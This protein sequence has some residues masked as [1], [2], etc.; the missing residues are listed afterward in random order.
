[1]TRKEFDDLVRRMERRLAGRPAALERSATRWMALGLAGFLA[2]VGL[3]FALGLV[4]FIA[5]IVLPF[6][7]GVWLL[8][9]GVLILLFATSQAF[10]FFSV[11]HAPP[12]GHALRAAEAPA[13]HEALDSLRRDLQCR[14]FDDVRITM[15]FNAGIREIP[16][17]GFLGWPRSILEIGLPL[18]EAL[19]PDELRAVLAHEMAHGSGRHARSAGRIYRLHR[20]WAVLFERMQRPASGS[21]D[22]A[23]RAA[24]S[25]FAGWYWPRLHARAMVLS[26]AHEY[27]ADRVAAEC[28]GT[29][30]VVSALW[31]ME[32]W[33]P[34]LGERFWEDLFR[35]AEESPDPPEDI[36]DRMRSAYESRPAPDDASRW[37]ER[38]LSRTTG[39]D[40]TH[41]AFGDRVRALGVS[42]EDVRRI[43]YPLA[44]RPSAAQALLGPDRGAIEAGLADQWRRSVMAGWRQRHRRATADTRRRE[45]S[46]ATAAED[47]PASS[48]ADT[49]AAWEEARASFE[50]SGPAV[51]EPLLRAVLERDPRH[52]GASLVLGGHLLKRGDPEG[53]RLLEQVAAGADESWM[54]P[55]CQALHDHFLATGQVERLQE[56]RSR[57]DR[58]DEESVAAQRERSTIRASDIFV[59]HGLGDEQL[60]PLRTVLGAQPDC[61]AAWLVRKELRYH[62]SRP[63]FVL[64]VRRRSA[65][66]WLAAPDRDRDLVRRLM[67]LV[68]LPGQVL[69]VA[70]NGSFRKLA[71][72]IMS[73]RDAE[74]FRWDRRDEEEAVEA[75]AG[76]AES[77]AG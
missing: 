16:R 61:G 40:E 19:T 62:P 14:P 52:P 65:R 67:P 50:R 39:I 4:A 59:P 46:G 10:V 5:G 18:M 48:S 51:A 35:G 1:M 11:E 49:F 27:H 56:M 70:R 72:K 15:E 23:I 73:R 77:T 64:C 21:F 24:A 26:R 66:W 71:A 28:T 8:I 63:L 36:M 30:I 31:R 68:E 7:A 33:Q 76:H 38:G 34:M 22:R 37:V 3:L 25:R 20:T 54:R 69:I 53:R 43:G 2:W 12:R 17:L 41:P 9:G 29:D 6:E 58:L 32:C 60:A 45:S 74:F 75:A 57:L 47:A 44:A 55:A 42:V 13:L